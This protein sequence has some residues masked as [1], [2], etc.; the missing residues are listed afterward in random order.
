MSNK[1]YSEA[2][3]GAF[4]IGLLG[5]TV[6]VGAFELGKW[7]VGAFDGDLPEPDPAQVQLLT[8]QVDSLNGVIY[9]LRNKLFY[10]SMDNVA[11]R[12]VLENN[13]IDY[14]R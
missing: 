12:S 10:I 2:V 13:N 1:K 14:T 7:A 3:A 8:A 5:T 9:D 4:V 11:Y 6:L